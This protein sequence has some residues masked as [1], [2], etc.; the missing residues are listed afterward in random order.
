MSPW[1]TW[2]DVKDFTYDQRAQ[3]F[4]GYSRLEARVDAQI[5]ELTA[6]RAAMPGAKDTKDWDFAMKEMADSRV[7]LHGSGESLGKAT[8]DTWNQLKDTAGVAWVRTQDAY[9]K[10]KA[11]TTN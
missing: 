7:Y 8:P 3:F 9:A 2:R 5:A 1:R 11:S 4:T 6:L 10:V